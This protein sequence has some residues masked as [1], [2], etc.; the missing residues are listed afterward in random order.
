MADS[1]KMEEAES[2]LRPD[3]GGFT[4][5]KQHP[6]RFFLLAMS[7]GYIIRHDDAS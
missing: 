6:L 5:R 3:V 7:V 1:G 2:L 4:V